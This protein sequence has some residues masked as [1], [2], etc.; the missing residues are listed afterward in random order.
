MTLNWQ[1]RT[2]DEV[3]APDK[4]KAIIRDANQ[5][6]DYVSFTW[7]LTPEPLAKSR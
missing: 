5:I 3:V 1:F 4:A 6:A 7:D 2:K